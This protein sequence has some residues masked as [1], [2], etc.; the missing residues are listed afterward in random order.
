MLPHIIS[1]DMKIY[2]N[3][4]ILFLG[5]AFEAV[6]AQQSGQCS[7]TTCSQGD[8]CCPDYECINLGKVRVHA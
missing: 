3:F 2:S 7:T 4:V 6:K 1:N 5:S 8:K